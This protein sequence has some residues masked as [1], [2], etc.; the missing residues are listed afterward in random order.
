VIIRLMTAGQYRADD[1]LQSRLDE[2]D[3]EAVAALEADDEERL[4]GA[5]ARMWQLVQAEGEE[6]PDDSLETSD[7][8][9]PPP[10]LTLEETR[11]LFSDQGLVPDLPE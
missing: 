8:I 5:L 1:A 7:A 10:D 3:D 4:D 9:I 11:A 2:L 6:L